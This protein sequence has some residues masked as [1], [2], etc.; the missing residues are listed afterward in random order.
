MKKY[1]TLLLLSLQLLVINKISAHSLEQTT[2]TT[3][4]NSTCKIKLLDEDRTNY[5]AIMGG[6]I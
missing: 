2:T 1:Q 4:S 3:Y 5:E 6:F